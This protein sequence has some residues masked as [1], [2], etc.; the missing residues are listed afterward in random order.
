[1]LED[2]AKN[3]NTSV[4]MKKDE[5]PSQQI[6]SFLPNSNNRNRSSTISIRAASSSIGTEKRAHRHAESNSPIKI[7]SKQSIDYFDNSLGNLA[8]NSHRGELSLSK[9]SSVPTN[10]SVYQTN[11]DMQNPTLNYRNQS[12]PVRHS[13]VAQNSESPSPR[14]HYNY[15][16]QNSLSTADSSSIRKRRLAAITKI[17]THTT[18]S[19]NNPVDSELNEGPSMVNLKLLLAGN[20][21]NHKRSPVRGTPLVNNTQLPAPSKV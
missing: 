8:M 6:Q 16:R 21:E 7:P 4:I 20:S 19:G 3:N 12:P 11:H 14:R 9:V 1:M 18:I 13:S 15:A 5:K 2:E 10:K 17:L